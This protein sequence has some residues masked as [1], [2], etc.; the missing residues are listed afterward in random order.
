[1]HCSSGSIFLPERKLS[2]ISSER[3]SERAWN[4]ISSSFICKDVGFPGAEE[5]LPSGNIVPAELYSHCNLLLFPRREQKGDWNVIEMGTIFRGNKNQWKQVSKKKVMTCTTVH[6]SVRPS[7]RPSVS[8]AHTSC[9]SAIACMQYPQSI[10][11][12][13]PPVRV[14]WTCDVLSSGSFSH[15]RPYEHLWD[16]LKDYGEGIPRKK[17]SSAHN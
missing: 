11:T 8:N 13:L 6:P 7:V 1:M 5:F 9:T 14:A 10:R 15:P 16:F 2:S 17:S 12:F 3:A 4:S